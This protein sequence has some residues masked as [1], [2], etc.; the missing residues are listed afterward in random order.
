MHR[1]RYVMVG[2]FC[3][4]MAAGCRSATKVTE[5]PRVDLELSGGNRG[6]LVGTPPP[7]AAEMKT[8]RRMVWTD[9]ELPSFSKP[10]THGTAPVSVEASTPPE[11][12]TAQELAT[13]G[14]AET[15]VQYDT[16]VVKKGDSL[17]TIAAKPEIYG[18]GSR[19]RRI[20]DANRG[21]LKSPDRVRAGMTLKIPRGEPR[22]KHHRTTG[23]KGVLY[24]K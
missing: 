21:L 10:T 5:V 8:T 11:A 20:F 13:G 18:K 2:G 6:Y 23:N 19:W 4:I 12:G 7:E 15:A 24:K 22:K 14:E 9:I 17:S 16:Y 3:L 1:I